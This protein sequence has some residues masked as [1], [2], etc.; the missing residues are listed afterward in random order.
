M[1]D[2]FGNYFS[3]HP[4]GF[5]FLCPAKPRPASPPL[6]GI[7]F[8]SPH[9]IHKNQRGNRD[10]S[11][12]LEGAGEHPGATWWQQLL[13]FW[14]F[15]RRFLLGDQRRVRALPRFKHGVASLIFYFI[16]IL[17]FVL[18]LFPQLQTAPKTL[19]ASKL[20]TPGKG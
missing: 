6:A 14:S 1:P 19:R 3:V 18:F 20:R 12:F 2:A 15:F 7:I 9:S 16:L 11:E 10:F 8:S 17:F 5:S 4:L 13:G